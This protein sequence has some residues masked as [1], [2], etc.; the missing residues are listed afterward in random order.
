[1]IIAELIVVLGAIYLG[2]RIGNIG[3][4]L[5]GGIGVLILT[6]G[7]GLK[8]GHIPIDVILIIM[9]VITAI[10]AMQVAG[11]RRNGLPRISSRETSTKTSQADH[12]SSPYRHLLYDA[13]C[14]NWTYC[15]FNLTCYSRSC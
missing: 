4:G 8:P 9:S 3:I 5:A 12:F 6:M 15:I 2:A 11:C 7:M 14:R 1:M 10:A 13:I